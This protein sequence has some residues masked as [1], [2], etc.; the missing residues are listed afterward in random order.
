MLEDYY[1]AIRAIGQSF[2]SGR[3]QHGIVILF[4]S[5]ICTSLK[6]ILFTNPVAGGIGGRII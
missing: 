2:I 1:K 5:G 3:T 6:I 4:H